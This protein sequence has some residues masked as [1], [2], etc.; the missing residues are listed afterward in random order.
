M[1]A[2]GAI[3]IVPRSADALGQQERHRL[4][5]RQIRLASA[6]RADAEDDVVAVDRF[7]I[8]ALVQALGND[9]PFRG[10]TD[11][12]LEEVVAKLNPHVLGYER[13]R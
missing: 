5:H 8:G 2:I 13:R 7:E 1:N 3:S 6:G 4:R 11:R 12:A 10:R 9:L